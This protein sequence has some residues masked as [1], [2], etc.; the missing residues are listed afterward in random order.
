MTADPV[1][2]ATGTLVGYARVSTAEQNLDLQVDAL[3]RAGCIRVFTDTASGSLTE[4][5]QLSAALDYLRRGDTLV[6]WRLDRLGRSLKHLLTLVEGLDEREIDFKSLQE[7]LDTTTPSGKLLFQ[8]MG[9]LAEFE[10]SLIRER[11]HAGLSAARARGRVGGRKPVLTP[12]KA[13]VARRLHDG[14]E[15]TVAEIAKILG[16]SRATIYRNLAPTSCGPGAT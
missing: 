1:T 10:R 14:K 9:A 6:V 7:S 8:V 13:A 15:H 4:R 12:H 16:V 5:P 3:H 2:S 11:T